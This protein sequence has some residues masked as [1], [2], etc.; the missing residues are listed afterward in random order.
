[1]RP[2]ASTLNRPG[3]RVRISS[4]TT[5]VQV[6]MFSISTLTSLVIARRAPLTSSGLNS[7]RSIWSGISTSSAPT[8]SA[9]PD[10]CSA[11]TWSAPSSWTLPSAST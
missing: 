8:G 2:L 9:V 4:V 3:R 7:V 1:M 11:I 6:S 5:P 10:C